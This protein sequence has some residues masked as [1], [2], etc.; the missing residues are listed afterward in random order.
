MK[1]FNE[2]DEVVVVKKVTEVVLG[3]FQN[4]WTAAMDDAIGKTFTVKRQDHR[5]VYFDDPAYWQGFPP[6]ALDLVAVEDEPFKKGDKVKVVRKVSR[7]GPGERRQGEWNWV[8]PMDKYIGETFEVSYVA[9]EGVYFKDGGRTACAYP[10]ASLALVT[11][12]EPEVKRL[13]PT[14]EFKE[15][16]VVTVVRSI[17]E[18]EE[19]EDECYWVMDMGPTI[20]EQ[21][22][23]ESIDELGV[24][25]VDNSYYYPR[26]SLELVERKRPV[27]S[28]KEILDILDQIEVCNINIVD[29]EYETTYQGVDEA[30]DQI[31]A[32]FALMR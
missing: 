9:D 24:R 22:V 17:E 8:S 21:H 25:L 18:G 19:L 3:E 5:G 23:I 4:T 15:G 30:A 29:G 26:A 1:T 16:D 13:V 20:G 32:L 11:E 28:K 31:L 12:E 10:R 27:P 7:E 6:A 14:F 2:G